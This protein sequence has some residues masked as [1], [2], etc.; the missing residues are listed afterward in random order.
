MPWQTTGCYGVA[1]AMGMVLE[2]ALF[3]AESSSEDSDM[4]NLSGEKDLERN[5]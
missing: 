1:K 5:R 2:M 4:H 3:K